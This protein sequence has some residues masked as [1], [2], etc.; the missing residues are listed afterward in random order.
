MIRR[1]SFLT[2]LSE[3]RHISRCR[4]GKLH[5]NGEDSFEVF[6]RTMFGAEFDESMSMKQLRRYYQPVRMAGAWYSILQRTF[7]HRYPLLYNALVLS[8]LGVLRTLSMAWH[9]QIP[10]QNLVQGADHCLSRTRKSY[11]AF[12]PLTVA[13]GDVIMLIKGFRV[14]L[15]LRGKGTKWE[16]IS[17]AYVPGLMKGEQW[18]EKLCRGIRIS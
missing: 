14:P 3:W 11:I 4:P 13:V 18:D 17:Y 15:V 1:S 5:P 8:G 10:G 2:T 6:L 16:L 7:I 9:R 12:T